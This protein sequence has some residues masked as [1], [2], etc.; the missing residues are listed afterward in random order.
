LTFRALSLLL[1]STFVVS[2]LTAADHSQLDASEALFTVMAAAN[3]AGYDAGLGTSPEI[4]QLVRDHIQ[5]VKPP[6][7]KEI[8]DWY[9]EYPAPD[10]TSDLSRF[11]SLGISVG[12]PPDFSWTKR[13]VDVPP[14]ARDMESFR[15]LLPRFYQEANIEDLWQKAQPLVEETLARY[16]EPIAKAVLEANAYLRNP[17]YGFLGRRFSIYIDLLGAPNQVQTR[18]YGDDYFVVLTPSSDLHVYEIR[19]AYFRYLI[20]PLSIKYGMELKE[21]EKLLAIAE[22]APLL[23]DP[24]RSHFDLLSTECLI[25]AI[26]SRLLNNPSMVDAAVKHGYILTPFFD[27]EL[28]IYEKQPDSLKRFFPVMVAALNVRRESK[29]LDGVQFAKVEDPAVQSSAPAK[30]PAPPVEP[31]QSLSAKSVLE[32]DTF[33]QKRDLGNALR[34]YQSALEQPGTPTDHAKAYFGLAHVA[35][36]QK[37]P[38]KADELFHKT[39]ESSPDAD[40]RAWSYYYL[41]KLA[42]AA[43]EH[44]E[45][46]KWYQ[47]AIAVEG[48]PSRAVE[49]ARNGM[50]N[51]TP[52]VK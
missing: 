20:D 27:E 37:D 51:P 45:A 2:Q 23:K 49:L 38:E 11:I 16:Q 19:H 35:L 50:E 25:K 15:A 46:V 33:Y 8:R 32:A 48:A 14:D 13:D 6:V 3:A 36:L 31:E 47:Q 30:A 44:G 7:L 22:G 34:L 26:E 52:A 43:E 10:K 28:R 39:L 12:D 18:S 21:K 42:D 4:R 41:G 29:R 9:R 40:R 17:T 1:F 24:Y 5:A